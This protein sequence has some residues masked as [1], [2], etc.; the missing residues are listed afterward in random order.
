MIIKEVKRFWIK[1]AKHGK[2]YSPNPFYQ[3][4]GW[5]RI[6]AAKLQKDPYCEC[7]ACKGKKAP[8]EMVDH[9]IPISLGGSPTDMSNLQSMTNN[10]HN[11]KSAKEKN[12]KYRK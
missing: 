2:R 12:E 7:D 5:K 6:R 9:K 1:E 4:Q 10:C 11:A 3:S 8:A